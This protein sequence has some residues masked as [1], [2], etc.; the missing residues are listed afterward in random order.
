MIRVNENGQVYVKLG[1]GDV[2]ISSGTVDNAYLMCFEHLKGFIKPG[3]TLYN[4]EIDLTNQAVI[5]D[6]TDANINVLDS[7]IEDLTV[8]R[9]KKRILQEEVDY[10]F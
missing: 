8:M 5:I 9:N 2:W 6:F 3:T 7:L 10:K 1:Y 4:Q